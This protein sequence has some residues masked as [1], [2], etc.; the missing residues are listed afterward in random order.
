MIEE[1]NQREEN[2]G[3]ERRER[4]ERMGRRE[5]RGWERMHTSSKFFGAIGPVVL[6]RGSLV[7]NV[8]SRES[9]LC[10]SLSL[11]NNDDRERGCTRNS[12]SVVLR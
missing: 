5:G 4:R 8:P 9:L 11:V 6:L 1:G 7:S 10:F 3:R 2:K 12:S